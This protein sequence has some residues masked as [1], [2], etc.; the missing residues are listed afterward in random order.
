MS[1]PGYL[2]ANQYI[3]ISVN[4]RW[5]ELDSVLIETVHGSFDIE[6]VFE[7]IIPETD[8]VIPS[9]AIIFVTI[10]EAHFDY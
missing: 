4:M 9:K 7:T 1:I 3:T 10:E 8:N 6:K 5:F 2:A